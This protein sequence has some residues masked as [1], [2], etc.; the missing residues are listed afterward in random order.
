VNNNLAQVLLERGERARGIEI[1]RDVLEDTRRADSAGQVHPVV[2]FNYATQ[3][4]GTGQLDSALYWYSMSASVAQAGQNLET[5]RRAQIGVA[6]ASS[7][8]G[9]LT[10]ARA[11]FEQV[12]S[13]ARRQKKSAVRDSLYIAASIALAARDTGEAT[14]LFDA[15]LKED[16][17]YEKPVVRSRAPLLEL[18]RLHLAGGAPAVG[19]E[20]A[21]VLHDL[22][23]TDSV[24]QYQS[25]DVGEADLLAARAFTALGSADS[26]AWYARAAAASLAVGAG[27]TNVLTVQAR[28]LA[29]SLR[30]A[31]GRN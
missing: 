26:A 14:R 23:M 8:L 28:A 29:D 3:L 31:R 13:I 16:G 7:K 17:Y 9:D 2:A 18:A 30:G 6:R 25:A 4:M 12:L 1:L 11:A 20:I 19:L 10:R 27:A 24:A 21:R 22:G 5:A 15:V